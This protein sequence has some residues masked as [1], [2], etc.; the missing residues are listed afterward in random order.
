M[1]RFKGARD[2]TLIDFIARDHFPLSRAVRELGQDTATKLAL[3]HAR[4]FDEEMDN[5]ASGVFEALISELG[6]DRGVVESSVVYQ[7]LAQKYPSERGI[8]I[9]SGCRFLNRYARS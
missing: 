6:V 4:I 9:F 7:G 5:V 3:I 8:F 1:K 2:E